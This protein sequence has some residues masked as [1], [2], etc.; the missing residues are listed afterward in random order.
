VSEDREPIDTSTPW[1]RTRREPLTQVEGE[2]AVYERAARKVMT[3]PGNGA[4]HPMSLSTPTYEPNR[5]MAPDP[6]S[7]I[8][9]KGVRDSTPDPVTTGDR[10]VHAVVGTCIILIFGIIGYMLIKL[11]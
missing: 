10:V 6:N 11:G 3:D 7:I 4:I 9:K 8:A 2:R 5:A 1:G